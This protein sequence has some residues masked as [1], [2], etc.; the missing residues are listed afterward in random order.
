[1]SLFVNNEWEYMWLRDKKSGR[2]EYRR[3]METASAV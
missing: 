2:I 3:R 1:M